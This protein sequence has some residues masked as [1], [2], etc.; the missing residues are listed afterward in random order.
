MGSLEKHCEEMLKQ[1]REL[2]ISE[3]RINQ[4]CS[5]LPPEKAREAVDREFKRQRDLTDS[6][7]DSAAEQISKG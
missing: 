1:R 5:T 7:T 3:R 4:A 2:R 6:A